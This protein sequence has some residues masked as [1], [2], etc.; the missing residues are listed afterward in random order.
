[1]LFEKQ[2]KITSVLNMINILAVN[3]QLL[4]NIKQDKNAYFCNVKSKR[5]TLTRKL[6]LASVLSRELVIDRKL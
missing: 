1:M 5:H 6:T 4:S 2:H 3:N